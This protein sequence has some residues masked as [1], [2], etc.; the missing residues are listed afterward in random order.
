MIASPGLS[1][2]SRNAPLK[3]PS[4]VN[5]IVSLTASV[6]LGS[7]SMATVAPASEK[8]FASASGAA[9]SATSA[10]VAA[11]SARMGPP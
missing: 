6:P 7:T 5:V 11:R 1:G 10:A 9:A 4:N 8:D 3:E 2:I